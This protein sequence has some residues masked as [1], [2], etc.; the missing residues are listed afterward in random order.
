RAARH[1]QRLDRS[2]GARPSQRGVGGCVSP[3]ASRQT[4][5]TAHPQ[6]SSTLWLAFVLGLRH[7]TDP[8]HLT[9]IDG[10]S[11]IRPR[12]TNGLLF[13]LGHGLV[14]PPPAAGAGP[15]VADRLAF[16]GPWMLILIGVVNLWKIVRPTPAA[17]A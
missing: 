17:A 6:M 9:A 10:L 12:A 2:G 16:V 15:L 14:V 5:R 3:H 11:R 13:A 1:E 4:G 8:D 7:G